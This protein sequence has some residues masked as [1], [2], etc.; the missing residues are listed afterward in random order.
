MGTIIVNCKNYPEVL[1]AG[2]VRL[3]R[4]V[5]M[6]SDELGV[7]GVVAPPTPTLSLV[8]SES[9]AKV[10]SQSVGWEEGEKTT[11]AVV[12]AA[13][14][15][16]G[17]SGTLLN[18]SEARVPRGVLAKLVPR[19]AE[20][21][22][23]VCLCAQTSVEAAELAL[24]GPEFVAIEPPE[25]IGSGVAV[26]RAR[27]ELVEETVKAVRRSGFKGGILCGAGIV[28]GEDVER[29][30]SLGVDGVLVASSVVKARDWGSKVRELARSLR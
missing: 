17:A 30:V 20:A 7:A 29:A 1:G 15:A 2:A 8:A 9:G 26:S 22:L 13:V 6:A 18:H 21:G 11:G 23:E 10:Y 27:P 12:P 4:A 19:L 28:T 25:L 3:A 14:M 5:K 24:L 16:A